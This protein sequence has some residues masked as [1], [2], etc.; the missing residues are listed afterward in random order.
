MSWSVYQKNCPTRVILDRIADKWTVL[1]IGLL[2]QRPYRFNE[3]RRGLDGISQKVLTQALRDLERDGVI[4][5]TVL[6]GSPVKVQY[7]LTPFGQTL[8]AVV[9]QLATWAESNVETILKA[10]AAYQA[11]R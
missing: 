11:D 10:R 4:T 9:M 1:L 5:R 6:A 2:V 3:L 8:A 7:A